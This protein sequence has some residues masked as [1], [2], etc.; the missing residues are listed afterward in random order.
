[1]PSL[2]AHNIPFFYQQYLDKL[3]VYQP[4]NRVVKK[5]AKKVVQCAL[6]S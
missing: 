2:C 3:K 1:M 5:A 4:E 6:S